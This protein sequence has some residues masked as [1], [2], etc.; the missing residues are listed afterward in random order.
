MPQFVTYWNLAYSY[1]AHSE[2]R[3]NEEKTGW[4]KEEQRK[5]ER[6]EE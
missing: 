6:K 1:K 3:K 5:Q 4:N 2:S